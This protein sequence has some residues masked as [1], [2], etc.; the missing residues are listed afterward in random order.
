MTIAE[1]EIKLPLGAVVH[2]ADGEPWVF[3]GYSWTTK[4]HNLEFY[5]GDTRPKGLER[6]SYNATHRAT[7]IRK[8]PD[9]EKAELK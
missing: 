7:L 2:D 3:V 9:I 6:Y 4:S 8:F 1:P 5:K